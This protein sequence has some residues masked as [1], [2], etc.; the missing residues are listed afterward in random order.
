MILVLW[1]WTL[2]LANPVEEPNVMDMDIPQL[3]AASTQ[4]KGVGEVD[5]DVGKDAE[6]GKDDVGLGAIFACKDDFEDV[7]AAYA[8]HFGRWKG[9]KILQEI[10]ALSYSCTTILSDLQCSAEAVVK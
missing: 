1:K 10:T 4:G 2:Y 3:D 9:Y 5:V 7:I 8:M 6:H